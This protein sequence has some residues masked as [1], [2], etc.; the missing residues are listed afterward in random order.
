MIDRESALSAIEAF[1]SA[2][3]KNLNSQ[4]LNQQLAT[5]ETRMVAAG[6]QALNDDMRAYLLRNLLKTKSSDEI[7][8][9]LKTVYQLF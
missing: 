4:A 7:S 2:P 1:R 3:I 9:L 5:L 8:G 6:C